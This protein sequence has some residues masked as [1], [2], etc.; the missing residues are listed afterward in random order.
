MFLFEY[1][2][3]SMQPLFVIIVVGGPAGKE[4]RSDVGQVRQYL[5]HS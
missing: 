2:V 5:R 4:S 1:T 3:S